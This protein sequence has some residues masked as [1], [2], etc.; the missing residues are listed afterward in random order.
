MFEIENEV[1]EVSENY[2][3]M[4]ENE[5]LGQIGEVTTGDEQD[6][7]ASVT[8]FRCDETDN[9]TLTQS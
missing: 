7:G 9:V 3:E 8:M 1:F 6:E 5:S 2:D 4:I